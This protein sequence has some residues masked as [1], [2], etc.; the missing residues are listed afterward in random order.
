MDRVIAA[1][2][3][4]NEHVLGVG[5][6]LLFGAI[7]AMIPWWTISAVQLNRT[8][9]LEDPCPSAVYK[10]NDLFPITDTFPRARY[11]GFRQQT[12]TGF[13]IVRFYRVTST[14]EMIIWS[15]LLVA[16]VAVAIV[17][18]SM[19]T[20]ATVRSARDLYRRWRAVDSQRRHRHRYSDSRTRTPDGARP[21]VGQVG[22][23]PDPD[24][25]P[26]KRPD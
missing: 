3:G 12:A 4:R 25:D 1:G 2:R 13:D 9:W 15:A 7:V 10:R 11:C 24:P 6:S 21:N 23:L 17:G 26:G 5:F 19:V 20:F 14:G 8:R 16:I 22:H 18:L